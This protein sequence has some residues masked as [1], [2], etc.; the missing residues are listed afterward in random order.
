MKKALVLLFIIGMLLGVSG[1]PYASLTV[2]GTASYQGSTYNL[3]YQDNG[4]FGPI[5]W[6]DYTSPMQN[7]TWQNQVNWASTLGSVSNPLT[8][9]LSPGC[10][11]AIDWTTGWRLPTTVD[12]P[13]ASGYDGTTTAGWNITTSEMGRL[14]Y[15]ELGN[16]GFYDTNGK[17]Q[18]EY[19]LR[20]S[21]PFEH[22]QAGNYWSHTDYGV[23]PVSAW[24]FSFDRGRQG[25]S[26][27]GTTY[28]ALAVRP[29]EVSVSAVLPPNPVP[30]PPAVWLF[31]TGILGLFGVRRMIR[32]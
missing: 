5:T 8:V 25:Y 31:G 23:Y 26:N 18:S 12:G 27:K 24:W 22:L 2:I 21:G 20:N 3:I 7:G 6:M 14:Y 9:T 4:P 32:K 11:S 15:T 30:V 28:D 13:Y 29:G 10:T 19:G 1:T 17:L 16:K